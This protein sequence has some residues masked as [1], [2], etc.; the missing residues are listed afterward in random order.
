M[1][2]IEAILTRRSVRKFTSTPLEK[3]ALEDL[4]KSAM[5]APS[6][7]NRQPWHFII[8]QDKKK[9]AEIAAIHP[10][11]AMA[12]E[13]SAA[14]LIAADSKIEETEGLWVQD[15]SAAMQNLLLAAHAKKMGAVWV[16]LYPIAEH[17][18]TFQ[19]LF[20]LPQEIRPFS[21]AILGNPNETKASEDRFKKER[22]HYE[23]W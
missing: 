4:V 17:L 15:C 23:K 18:E 7:Y 14:I 10:Y 1:Q 20:N 22:L 6:A 8:I 9:L 21:L 5:S 3:E 11:A 13:A 2:T 12:S 19:K 16:G